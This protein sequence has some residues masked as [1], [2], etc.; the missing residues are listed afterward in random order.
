MGGQ[1]KDDVMSVIRRKLQ[2]KLSKKNPRDRGGGERK[3]YTNSAS[4]KV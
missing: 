2:L 4:R 1:S 3:H